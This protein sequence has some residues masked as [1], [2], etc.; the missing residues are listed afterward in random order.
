MEVRLFAYEDAL[1]EI[2]DCSGSQ[3][4]PEVAYAFQGAYEKNKE[5]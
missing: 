3:F 2:I 5:K 1:K 4:N